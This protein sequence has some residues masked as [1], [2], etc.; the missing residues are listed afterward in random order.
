VT[1]EYFII[2]TDPPSECPLHGPYAITP[3]L[4]GYDTTSLTPPPAFPPLDTAPRRRTTRTTSPSTP[5]AAMPGAVL[6]GAVIPGVAT[7][8][9]PSRGGFRDTTVRRPARRD[10][11]RSPRDTTLPPGP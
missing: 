11:L 8:P 6:P 2:G 7:P 1:Q 4:P 10:S 5:A 9:R 3:G